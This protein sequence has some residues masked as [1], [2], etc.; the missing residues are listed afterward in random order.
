MSKPRIIAGQA[1]GRALETPKQGT[2]PSPSRLR[3]ALFNMLAFSQGRFVDLY[4]GSGAVGL[5]AASRGWQ[6]SC[7]DLSRPAVAVI[8]RNAQR[9]GLDA[10]VICDD[11]LR[12][13]TR[14]AE[15]FDVVFAAPPYPL[16]LTD[17]FQAILVSDAIVPCGRYIFQHPSTLHLQLQ[18]PRHKLEQ[19]TRRYGSNALTFVRLADTVSADTAAE[20]DTA[21]NSN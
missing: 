16:E 3:E 9:L 6:V 2:R 17:I 18:H 7:V 20:S 19:D 10:E 12:Y 13:I 8:R 1:K 15:V 21:T 11:A 14:Q 5:E 4:S